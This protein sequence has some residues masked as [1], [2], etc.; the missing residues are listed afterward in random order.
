MSISA[1]PLLL[2]DLVYEDP[3]SH[4]VT[5]LGIFTTVRA[6]K[7]P[8]PYR[9]MSIYTQLIGDP[10]EVGELSLQ[11][12]SVANGQVLAAESYRVQIGS[13]GKRHVHIRLDELRFPEPG[14]YCFSLLV[15]N[16]AIAEQ[17]ILVTE[18]N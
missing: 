14:S 7:F 10:G 16:H 12:E 2:C 8:T 18:G 1:I 4:N 11:C 17:T 5:L 6:T 15:E 13:F 9:I 3:V